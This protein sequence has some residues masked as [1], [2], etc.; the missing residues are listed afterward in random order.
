MSQTTVPSQR[1]QFPFK[2]K[3]RAR[4][5][6]PSPSLP[7]PPSPVF[8][9]QTGAAASSFRTS[10]TRKRSRTP[11]SAS[12]NDDDNNDTPEPPMKLQKKN[13][14]RP[15]RR[16]GAFY[17]YPTPSMPAQQAEDIHQT[18][19]NDDVGEPQTVHINLVKSF[20]DQVQGLDVS[21]WLPHGP[22]VVCDNVADDDDDDD[23]ELFERGSRMPRAEPQ[24]G[25]RRKPRR[26]RGRGARAEVLDG[27]TRRPALVSTSRVVSRT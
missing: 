7:T 15:L 19:D 8:V 20:L 6:S 9:S 24:G 3:G 1:R 11:E 25:A 17:E 22:F 13:R 26:G 18:D 2:A 4:T 27:A 12:D 16:E 5:R 23:D 21:G 10:K 14:H